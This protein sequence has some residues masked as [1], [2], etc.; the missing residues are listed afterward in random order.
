MNEDIGNIL[1][2]ESKVIDLDEIKGIT[3]SSSRNFAMV[4]LRSKVSDV[5]NDVESGV[6]GRDHDLYDGPTI[7]T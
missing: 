1:K 7:G 5:S 3:I 6:I 2:I 4:R